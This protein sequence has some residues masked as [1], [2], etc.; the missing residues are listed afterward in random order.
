MG[1]QSW[2]L[3]CPSVGLWGS[4]EC[5]S[6]D[7]GLPMA[8]PQS[9][10]P[11]NPVLRRFPSFHCDEFFSPSKYFKRSKE[12]A[13]SRNPN[14]MK[15]KNVRKNNKGITALYPNRGP[16]PVR[17]PREPGGVNPLLRW[18][19]AG[20]GVGRGP[21][22]PLPAEGE[23]RRG[24]GDEGG[25]APVWLYIDAFSSLHFAKPAQAHL[26]PI[27][28]PHPGPLQTFCLGASLLH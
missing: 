23:G 13:K 19:R 18:D 12:K 5:P 15:T 2:K 11:L 28:H 10:T 1:L 7:P 6:S 3:L 21:L 20:V 14:T 24:G 25:G 4:V 27:P 8:P 9:L 22:R 26:H 16:E 17:G